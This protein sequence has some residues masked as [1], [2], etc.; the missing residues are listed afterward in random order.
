LNSSSDK[1]IKIWDINT[2]ECIHTFDTHTEQVWSVAYNNDGS[3]LVSV[4]DDKSVAVHSTS[5]S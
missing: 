2:K 5:D 3:K 1:R 4:S